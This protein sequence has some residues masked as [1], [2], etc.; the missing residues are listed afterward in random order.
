MLPQLLSKN[1]NV[2]QVSLVLMAVL[3]IVAGLNHFRMPEFYVS[4][5]PPIFP[6]PHFLV[7]LSGVIEI[8][9]GAGLLIPRTRKLAAWGVIALLI[10]IFPANFYMFQERM[11]I[12]ADVP[13]WVL[14]L[15]LPF[16]LV[17]LAWAYVYT[18]DTK[19]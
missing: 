6:E 15:R 19:S 13:E 8:A 18:K 2:Y 5:M 10:A 4:M 12:F 3:Y 14:I 7:L 9:L 16:Q 1:K 17:L 11:G